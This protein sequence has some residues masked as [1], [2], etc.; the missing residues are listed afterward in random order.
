MKEQ[1]PILVCDVDLTVVDTL[2]TWL[3]WYEDST[4]H[5]IDNDLSTVDYYLQDLMHKHD[6]PLDYWKKPNLYDKLLPI[7]EAVECLLEL[8]NYYDVLFVSSCFPEHTTS[9]QKFLKEWFPF[10]KG[11][12]ATSDKGFVKADA[13]IDDYQKNL[14]MFTDVPDN[15]KFLVETRINSKDINSVRWYEIKDRLLEICVE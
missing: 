9:K 14:L 8:K 11:F 13:V 4:G 3:K 10:A 5:N 12:I 2:D 15:M 6:S 7:P 1:K